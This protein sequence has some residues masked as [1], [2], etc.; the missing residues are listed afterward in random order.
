ML[1][2]LHLESRLASIVLN[3][4]IVSD[5]KAKAWEKLLELVTAFILSHSWEHFCSPCIACLSL[6][7]VFC[8]SFSLSMVLGG[9]QEDG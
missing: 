3:S 6:A 8:F 2:L 5:W 4:D 1:V 7:T 9:L